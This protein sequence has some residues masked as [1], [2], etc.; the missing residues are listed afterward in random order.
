MKREP[1]K[2]TL[3]A[4][5]FLFTLIMMISLAG[6]NSA[7]AENKRKVEAKFKEYLYQLK[8]TKEKSDAL[9][10]TIA[11]VHR[12]YNEQMIRYAKD[13][14]QRWRDEEATAAFTSTQ[15][16]RNDLRFIKGYYKQVKADYDD[17][18]KE[19]L[20]TRKALEALIKELKR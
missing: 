13:H 7:V 16:E 9:A 14:R 1:K 6:P 11:E 17:F 18:V 5:G 19:S 3:T 2:R 4:L 20:E 12:R 15:M 8:E 10:Q